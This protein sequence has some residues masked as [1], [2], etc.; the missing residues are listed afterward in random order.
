MPGPLGSIASPNGLITGGPSEAS[1]LS[2]PAAPTP[3]GSGMLRARAGTPFGMNVTVSLPQFAV[4]MLPSRSETVACG[5]Q[6]PPCVKPAAGDFGEPFG[7]NSETL[8]CVAGI[9]RAGSGGTSSGRSQAG[10]S[11]PKFPTQTLPCGSRVIPNPAP[12]SPPPK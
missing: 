2:F 1:G 7:R 8:S 12:L 4:Q 10:D 9:L 11:N 3:P 5:H 6:M